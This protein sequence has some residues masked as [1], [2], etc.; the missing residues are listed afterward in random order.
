MAS[1]SNFN[2]VDPM[3]SELYQR[4]VDQAHAGMYAHYDR[5]SS[6]RANFDPASWSRI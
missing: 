6:G 1:G 3:D 4:D 2:A 5:Q